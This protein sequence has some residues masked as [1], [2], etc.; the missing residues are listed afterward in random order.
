MRVVLMTRGAGPDGAFG[1]GERVIE[2][3]DVTA[4]RMVAARQ[5]EYTL[6]PV[7]VPRTGRLTRQVPVETATARAGG[8]RELAVSRNGRRVH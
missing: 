6:E 1:P 3:D 2:V 7:T 4:M 5:A 8:Q